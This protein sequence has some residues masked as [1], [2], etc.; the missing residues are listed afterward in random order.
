M[1]ILVSY[2]LTKHLWIIALLGAGQALANSVVYTAGQAAVANSTARHGVVA[3]GQGAYEATAAVGGFA[4]SLLAPLIYHNPNNPRH[5]NA[6]AAL[7]MWATMATFVL[8]AAM[9]SRYWA[10]K[11]PAHDDEPLAHERTHTDMTE[12]IH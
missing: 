12:I 4:C 2:G 8:I 9:A 11:A 6:F 1:P 3:A 5:P 7:P 10:A